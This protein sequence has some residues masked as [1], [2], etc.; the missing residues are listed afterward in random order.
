MK[1]SKLLDSGRIGFPTSSQ[2]TDIYYLSS[3]PCSMEQLERI[4]PLILPENLVVP[5]IRRYQTSMCQVSPGLC[6]HSHTLSVQIRN[7]LCMRLRHSHKINPLSMP[8]CSPLLLPCSNPHLTKA[9]MLDTNTDLPPPRLMAS[10]V[11]NCQ[12]RFSSYR[13]NLASQSTLG[14]LKALSKEGYT[15]I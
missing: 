8:S 13:I 12:L 4:T 7:V 1:Q 15:V 5:G 3:L 11:P 9:P 14:M 2:W 6:V 10:S